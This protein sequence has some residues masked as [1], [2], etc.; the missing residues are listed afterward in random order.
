MPNAQVFT[1]GGGVVGFLNFC[2]HM[3]A[4]MGVFQS[5]DAAGVIL[6]QQQFTFDSSNSLASFTFND[7]QGVCPADFAVFFQGTQNGK[8]ASVGICVC[9]ASSEPTECSNA[10]T[11]FT[12]DAQQFPQL[13]GLTVN[14]VMFVLYG[15]NNGINNASAFKFR[16]NYNQL[17]GQFNTQ[18]IQC[19][20]LPTNPC[21]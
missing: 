3:Y 17:V 20:T 19:P 2:G 12:I 11:E 8:P 14:N 9:D 5:G 4:S 21:N 15:D 13:N 16:F 18:P 6:P 1:C 10:A 7:L